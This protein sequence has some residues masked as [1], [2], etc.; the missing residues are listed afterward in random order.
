MN[1]ITYNIQ[2]DPAELAKVNEKNALENI[3]KDYDSQP[4]VEHKTRKA[5]SKK[6]EKE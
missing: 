5:A 2:A 6:E 3:G 1:E 4:V